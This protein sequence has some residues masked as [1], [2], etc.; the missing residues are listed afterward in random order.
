[1]VNSLRDAL[2]RRLVANAGTIAGG[3]SWGLVLMPWQLLLNSPEF[4]TR[5][6]AESA[7]NGNSAV[8]DVWRTANSDAP[9]WVWWTS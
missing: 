7:G 8:D 1:V 9:L 2:I 4:G 6:H 3:F 5:G